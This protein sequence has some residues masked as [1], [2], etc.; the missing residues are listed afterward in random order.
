MR[1]RLSVILPC[2]NVER[3]ISR[4]LDSLFDQ[5]IPYDEYEVICVDD[6]SNDNL[7]DKVRSYQERYSNI[8]F[9]QHAVNQTA[10][11]ARNTGINA[12][13]GDYLWF[14]D[15]DDNVPSN[16][17]NGFLSSAE[18]QDADIFQFNHQ[19]FDKNGLLLNTGAI[20]SISVVYS[21][22]EYISSQFNGKLAENCM[23]VHAFYKRKFLLNNK[24]EFPCIRASQ[25]VV[26]AWKSMLLARRVFSTEKVGYFIHKRD[27]STTGT[28]GRRKADAV[29]SRTV[30]F[31]HHL[32]QLLLLCKTPTIASGLNDVIRW[33]VNDCEYSLSRISNKERRN[34]HSLSTANLPAFEDLIKYLNRRNRIILPPDS[35]YLVWRCKIIVAF[36]IG[37]IKRYTVRNC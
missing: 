31:P 9:I 14:V 11:G 20:P 24:I 36:T 10:G 37:R 21:G 4:C 33:S 27:N 16:V 15:P 23:M 19:T 6:C 32:C 30:L 22:E 13:S 28:K 26:F 29:F 8:V 12:A 3:Y 35:N 17:L 5:D 25:D 18:A 7:I 1:K 34:F 2:Y